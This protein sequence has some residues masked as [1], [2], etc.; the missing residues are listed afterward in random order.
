M[1]LSRDQEAIGGP[2]RASL[3]AFEY[4][5]YLVSGLFDPDCLTL[6]F[7]SE[8]RVRSRNSASLNRRDSSRRF[9]SRDHPHGYFPLNISKK[10]QPTDGR[11]V[12]RQINDFV[13]GDRRGV[14][15]WPTVTSIARC[16]T[17]G[18]SRR[19]VSIAS[20][21]SRVRLLPVRAEREY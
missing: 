13:P 1:L 16:S 14:S 15:Q 11:C 17:R 7:S 9:E 2:P 19:S 3:H 4:L 21:T 8:E 6:A 20:G 10:K 12:I 18:D 5:E